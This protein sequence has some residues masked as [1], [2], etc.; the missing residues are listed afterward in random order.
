[1][2]THSPFS[3]ATFNLITASNLLFLLPDP[4]VALSEMA[5]LLKRNGEIALL[6][7]SKKM[8]VAAA[9][10]LADG[11]GLTGL[12]RETLLSY[13]SRAERHIRWGVGELEELFS[14]AGCTLM[15]TKPKMGRGLVLFVRGK[16]RG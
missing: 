5:R 6:N 3:S 12:A 4:Q 11:R 1:M 13:A 9:A 10:T 2:C 14:S 15:A 7:P 16:Y 8:S